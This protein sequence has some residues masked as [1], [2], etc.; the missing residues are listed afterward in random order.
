MRLGGILV[1]RG[2]GLALWLECGWRVAAYAGVKRPSLRMD[3]AATHL[4]EGEPG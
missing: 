2:V 3:A 1:E 4:Q